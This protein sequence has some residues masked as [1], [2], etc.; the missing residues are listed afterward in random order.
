MT[1]GGR[2]Q[3]IAHLR[4]IGYTAWLD[5]QFAKPVSAQKPYLD[6]LRSQGQGVYQSQRQEVWFIHSA[7][8][9]NPSNPGALHDDQLRQR[10]AFAQSEIMVVS[11]RNATLTFQPWALADYYDTLAHNAFGNFG[12]CA[13]GNPYEADWTSP[14]VAVEAFHDS[15]S[16]KQLLNDPN[17]VPANGLLQPWPPPGRNAAQ[18]LDIALDNLF[19]HPNVGPFIGRQLIQ[20]LVTSNPSPAYVS[21]VAAAFNN[22]G[23]GV[24]GDALAGADQQHR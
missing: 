2:L 21:R 10:V 18:E 15:T 7:Q 3:D 20:R 16:A 22:N 9:A 6:W 11:D 14:M 5:E 1:F 13:P 4:T 12:D 23:S 24:R 19:H 8:L 17:A